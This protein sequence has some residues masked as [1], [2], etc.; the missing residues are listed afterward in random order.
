[1]VVRVDVDSTIKDK[2]EELSK[3]AESQYDKTIDNI[4]EK[5]MQN[6]FIYICNTH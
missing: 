3:Y 6:R 2:I 5:L 1:M 4:K